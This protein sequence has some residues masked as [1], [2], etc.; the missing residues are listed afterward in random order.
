MAEGDKDKTPANEQ[1]AAPPAQLT[2]EQVAKLKPKKRVE[3]RIIAKDAAGNDRVVWRDK[4]VDA[5]VVT[6]VKDRLGF[7]IIDKDES[8]GRQWFR[9]QE[10]AVSADTILGFRVAADRIF[11]TTVDG[12]KLEAPLPA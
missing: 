3:E 5:R 6:T 1:A 4:L 2:K 9:T 10:V 11:V 7:D 12:Q 8:S